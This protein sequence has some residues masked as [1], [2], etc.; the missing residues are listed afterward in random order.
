MNDIL[1][2]CKKIKVESSEKVLGTKLFSAKQ[3]LADIVEEINY[4]G[5]IKPYVENNL[6]IDARKIA[7]NILP[8]CS[9]KN[10]EELK[11]LLNSSTRMHRA[12]KL[13]DFGETEVFNLEVESDNEMDHNYVVFTKRYT[14]LLVS[15]S[16]AAIVSREMGIPAVVGTQEATQKLKE[17]EIITVDGF[18]GKIYKGKVSENI[19]KEV[20]PMVETKIKIK[21]TVDLPSFAERASHSKAKEVGLTRIEGIISESGKHPF[22][23]LQKDKIKDYEEI[24]FEGINGIAKYFEEVWVRTSDLRS[25]EYS[26]L[27]GAPKEKEQNPMLGMHGIRFGLKKPSILKAELNALKRVSEK[28][29]RI[30]LLLPQIISVEEVM[31][32]KEVLKE[33]GFLDAKIGVMIETPASVQIIRELCEEGID[34]I[35]FG[36]NDLTQYTLAIDR[37]NE[38]VQYIY[39]EMHPAML[40][41]LEYVIKVCK[42]FGVESSICGQAGS[43][44]EMV[45]VLFNFGID[46]ISV[47][48][49]AAQE[50]SKFVAELEG[51]SEKEI[52]QGEERQ[53]KE[54]EEEESSENIQ[55]EIVEK[56]IEEIDSKEDNLGQEKEL[57]E[58]SEEEPINEIEEEI[59]YNQEEN[60]KIKQ[61]EK[62]NNNVLDIF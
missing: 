7:L 35:S 22:Y 14:P 47:N 2:Y 46:S 15:N 30:G 11:N 62:P 12:C 20:L 54:V 39:N 16:H 37:N 48:A 19:Q 53:I 59:K 27:E 1:Q 43:K 28:G 41:Q 56:P 18:S 49:D 10:K 6:L 9:G 17:N 38:E 36:T 4:K 55:E 45:D 44:K 8:L 32:V 3:V 25:D 51:K 34:F 31:E 26:N 13:H 33:I 52:K 23:F 40:H 57:I 29:K 61:E 21:V 42:E 60:E 58:E 50:I 24:I 5:R